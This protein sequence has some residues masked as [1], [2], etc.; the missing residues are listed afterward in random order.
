MRGIDG[1][2]LLPCFRDARF[3]EDCIHWTDGNAGVTVNAFQRIDEIL[4]RII[5]SLNAINWTHVYAGAI[6][7]SDTGFCDHIGHSHTP[8]R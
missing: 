2:V 6:L 1:N 3:L 7:H 8:L 4:I 5:C